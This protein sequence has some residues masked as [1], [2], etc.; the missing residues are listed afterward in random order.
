MSRC[1]R[2]EC[3][4]L[5]VDP[6]QSDLLRF[7]DM[8]PTEIIHRY[9]EVWNGRD[10]SKL[11]AAFTEDGKYCTPHVHPGLAGEAI[12]EFVK[13]AWKAFPDLHIELL[14]GGEIASLIMSGKVLRARENR[15]AIPVKKTGPE[16]TPDL[17]QEHTKSND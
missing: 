4:Y 5:L 12:A 6:R 8:T 15:H 13:A 14:N 3:D 16:N 9:F 7:R 11:L 17:E 2:D 1:S 10:A